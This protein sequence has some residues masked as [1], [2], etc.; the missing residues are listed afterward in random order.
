MNNIFM[1]IDDSDVE[2]IKWQ[3]N[4]DSLNDMAGV[5][6]KCV[7]GYPAVILFNPYNYNEKT[8]KKTINHMSVSNPLWLTCP[9]LNKR[10]HNLESEGYIKKITAFIASE[11]GI[12]DTM[13]NAHAHYYYLRHKLYSKTFG[14]ISPL[15]FNSKILNTGIGG[16]SDVK[17]IKCLHQHYSH[18]LVCSENVA[19]RVVHNLL[20]GINYCR[21]RLCDDA[22]S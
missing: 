15:D 3:L 12:M 7:H 1:P 8:G 4:C 16:I 14:E 17:N 6:F 20:N 9:Y 10:I 18:F 22:R 2:T 19:G 13:K 5:V 21:E 11:R